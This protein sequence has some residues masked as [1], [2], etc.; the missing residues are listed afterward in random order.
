MPFK[1]PHV[2]FVS[3]AVEATSSGIVQVMIVETDLHLN[4]KHRSYDHPAVQRL[5][6]A[7]Q[8]YVQA[9]MEGLGHVRLVSTRGGES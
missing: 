8:D 5:V 3:F 6:A 7:A 9:N 4:P 1:A 2:S